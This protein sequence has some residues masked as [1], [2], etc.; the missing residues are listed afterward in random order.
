MDSPERIKAEYDTLAKKYD[1]PKWDV[2]NKDIEILYINDIMQISSPLSLVMNR[3]GDRINGRI[4][5]LHAIVNPPQTNMVL[6][7]EYSF[8]SD[9]DRKKIIKIMTHMMAGMV[10]H[11]VVENRTEKN[12]ADAVKKR[13]D[14]WKKTK[15]SYAK[16][17]KKV[18]DGWKKEVKH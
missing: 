1:L 14:T 9:E 10:H 13:W 12:L 3:I 6:I 15:A 5:Y 7:K 2:I 11:K 17:V 8:L 4:E 18:D 16:I